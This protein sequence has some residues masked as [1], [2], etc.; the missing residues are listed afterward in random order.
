MFYFS[1]GNRFLFIPIYRNQVQFASRFMQLCVV[2]MHSR[3]VAAMHNV[4]SVTQK[5]TKG[6]FP[7]SVFPLDDCLLETH[8]RKKI[9]KIPKSV[10]STWAQKKCLKTLFV[11]SCFGVF[12][13]FFIH[14]LS[15]DDTFR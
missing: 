12:F 5:D 2:F 6:Q 3:K 11:V 8:A 13:F 9:K 15:A 1:M 10:V 4:G 14:K 7:A